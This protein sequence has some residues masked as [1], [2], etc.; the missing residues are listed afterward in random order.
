MATVHFHVNWSGDGVTFVDEASYVV[1]FGTQRGRQNMFNGGSGLYN[2][3]TGQMVSRDTN[4]GLVQPKYGEL[5]ATLNNNDGRYDPYNASSALYPNVKPF[6][7]CQVYCVVGVTTYYLFTGTLM[8]IQPSG[9]Y[10][11]TIRAVDDLF[12]LS[13]ISCTNYA[14]QVNQKVDDII[15]ILLTMG[16][17]AYS[18]TIEDAGDTIPYWWSDPEQNILEAIQEIAGAFGAV[19]Y[20][21]GDGTF[22]Y[23]ARNV[24]SASVQ[25]FDDDSINDDMRL[26]QPWDEIYNSIRVIASPLV[27]AASGQIWRLNYELVLDAGAAITLFATYA[28]ANGTRCPAS[29]VDTPVHT[30]DWTAYTGPGGTGTA[31]NALITVGITKYAAESILVVTNTDTQKLYINFMRLT[32]V[33]LQSLTTFAMTA[34]DAASIAAYGTSDLTIRNRWIQTTDVARDAAAYWKIL[35]CEPKRTLTFKVDNVYPD[36]FIP[37]LFSKVHCEVTEKFIDDNYQVGWIEHYW[38]A[39]E[40]C[41][42]TFRMEP[43]S[44]QYA[45]FWYFTAV[46]GVSTVFGW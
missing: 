25:T 2:P 43:H 41:V 28:D 17:W 26:S 34:S 18:S 44:S 22:V 8:D 30:T 13:K 33:I 36:Q 39:N 32:G 21:A 20:I 1:S 4:G 35:L 16:G 27:A 38:A 5:T 12:F 6:R 37:D 19:V 46:L 23:H 11:V 24:V 10:D 31:R 42:T 45:N 14:L 7:R 9:L 15:A 3:V 29:T 40:E